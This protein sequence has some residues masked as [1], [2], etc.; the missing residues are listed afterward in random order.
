MKWNVAA[1]LTSAIIAGP[2]VSAGAAPGSPG[3]SVKVDMRDIDTTTAEGAR[4]LYARLK[5]A[6]RKVS[7][8]E[9][10]GREIARHRLWRRNYD[11]ALADAVR[12]CANPRLD[13]LYAHD[14]RGRR[15]SPTPTAEGFPALP[16]A[17]RL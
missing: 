16:H 4:R 1:L 10:D 9:P 15:S 13:T 12:K 17:G 6:A 7:D 14:F 11:N 2:I 5:S 8:A 3:A